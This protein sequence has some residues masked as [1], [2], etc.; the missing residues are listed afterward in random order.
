MLEEEK[1]GQ[2]WQAQ[3]S[4]GG[5][6]E[7]SVGALCQECVQ[8]P[9][10]EELLPDSGDMESEWPMFSTSVVYAATCNFG[11]KACYTSHASV[12]ELSGG[13]QHRETY[14]YMK[15]CLRGAVKMNN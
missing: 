5:L 7:T 6:L 12:A 8:L 4:S 1:A 9:P 14:E 3:A 15:G 11:H 13:H 10:L 2:T